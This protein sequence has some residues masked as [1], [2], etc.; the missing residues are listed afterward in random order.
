[1]K[2]LVD[3]SV[4]IPCKNEVE[5]LESTVSSIINSKNYLNFEIIIVDDASTDLSTQFLESNKDIYKDV[6]L[7]KATNLGAAEARNTGAKFARGKYLFFCDAHVKVPD[8]WLDN[9]VNT[10]KNANASLVAPCIVDMT[11]T[12]EQVMVRRGMSS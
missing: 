3:V 10:L 6:T 9:L 12:L 8:L 2:D 4:I 7:I 11:N 1:M 5:N